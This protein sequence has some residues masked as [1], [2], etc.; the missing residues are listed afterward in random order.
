MA[1]PVV[2]NSSTLMCPHGGLVNILPTSFRVLASGAPVLP[3]TDQAVVTG[4]AS[5]NP[6]VKV[7]FAAGT[8]RAMTN[9]QPLVTASSVGH[10]LAANGA[11][12]GPVVVTGGD[13]RVQA[14]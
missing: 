6:C 4:C 8:T 12:G 11:L 10:C 2:T 14:S 7:Q 9:G 1:A 5:P 3:V 13:P